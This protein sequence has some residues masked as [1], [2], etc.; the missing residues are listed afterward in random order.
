M[1]AFSARSP[2][3][4]H[5]T[6]TIITQTHLNDTTHNAH[7]AFYERRTS[8]ANVE[9]LV[10]SPPTCHLL[11]A[12]C[13]RHHPRVRQRGLSCRQRGVTICPE[14]G[15]SLTPL[16]PSRSGLVSSFLSSGDTED[17]CEPCFFSFFGQP[18]PLFRPFSLSSNDFLRACKLKLGGD[19][20]RHCWP[21]S[22]GS[23]HRIRKTTLLDYA[24]LVLAVRFV[25]T[26][27]MV[28]FD[29][30]PQNY[31][32][33]HLLHTMAPRLRP[34]LRSPPALCTHLP[35]PAPAHLQPRHG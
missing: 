23:V 31:Q 29:S 27:R 21:L 5:N 10:S 32:V 7:A 11:A 34:P 4:I 16:T 12:R 26:N 18:F 22:Q 8:N 9:R 28:E 24:I 35:T 3:F 6:S 14:G 20:T 2:P 30:Q 13:S 19:R 33:K 17:D 15:L 1:R 25:E